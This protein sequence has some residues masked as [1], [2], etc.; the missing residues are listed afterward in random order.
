MANIK[1]DYPNLYSLKIEY[2]YISIF[3]SYFN[4][5]RDIKMDVFEF[6]FSYIFL[7]DSRS[8]FKNKVDI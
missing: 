6:I 1:L 7:F 5:I 4:D 8:I 3:V 2:I